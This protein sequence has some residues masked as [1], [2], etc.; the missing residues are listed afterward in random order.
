MQLQADTPVD[1]AILRRN[2]LE[3]GFIDIDPCLKTLKGGF[4]MKQTFQN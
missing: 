2:Q 4:L 3:A 1:L